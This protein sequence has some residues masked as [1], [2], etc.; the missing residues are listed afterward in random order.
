MTNYYYRVQILCWNSEDEYPKAYIV[1][2]FS[3][4]KTA[5][6]EAE[7]IL[8]TLDIDHRKLE[9]DVEKLSQSSTYLPIKN[10]EPFDELV[11]SIDPKESIDMEDALSLKEIGDGVYEIGVHISDVSSFMDLVNR[12]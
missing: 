4:V 8:Y 5:E 12:K 10:H 7:A 3:S 9:L 1:D 11:F 6:A 2:Q